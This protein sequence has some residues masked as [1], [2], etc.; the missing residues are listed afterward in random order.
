[1]GI[2]IVRESMPVFQYVLSWTAKIYCSHLSLP[3][4][5]VTFGYGERITEC[6]PGMHPSRYIWC[7]PGI[8]HPSHPSK[9]F[10][11]KTILAE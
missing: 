2:S 5:K 11:N 8:A 10:Q 9:S 1:M 7:H 4:N 6:S 3:R